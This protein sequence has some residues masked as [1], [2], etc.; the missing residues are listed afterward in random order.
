MST[1]QL[2]L[3][4]RNEAQSVATQKLVAKLFLVDCCRAVTSFHVTILINRDAYLKTRRAT[5]RDVLLDT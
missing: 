1:L 4:R 2:V 3:L 5:F